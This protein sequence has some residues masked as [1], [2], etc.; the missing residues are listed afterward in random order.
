M[1]W[2]GEVLMP[3]WML[4]GQ[5][6]ESTKTGGQGANQVSLPQV[7][8]GRALEN[9]LGLTPSLHCPRLEP[10]SSQHRIRALLQ[11]YKCFACMYVSIPCLCSAHRGQRALSRSH[12]GLQ[13]IIWILGTE[14]GSSTRAVSTL[15]HGAITPVSVFEDSTSL[16]SQPRFQVLI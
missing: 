8:G 11:V 13:V 12:R 14:H 5:V 9:C 2:S 7:D 6:E 16:P 3:G 1:G 4:N 10:D 15:S